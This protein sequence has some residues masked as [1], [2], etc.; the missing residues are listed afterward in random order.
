MTLDINTPAGEPPRALLDDALRE[1][2]GQVTITASMSQ[3]PP[4]LWPSIT[5]ARIAQEMDDVEDTVR[6]LRNVAHAAI[7]SIVRV[8]AAA[9]PT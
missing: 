7:A 5:Q 3:R 2:L 8:R 1:L 9:E 4:Q 6:A